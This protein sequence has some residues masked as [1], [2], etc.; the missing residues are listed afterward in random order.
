MGGSKDPATNSPSNVLL[1]CGSGT[2][3]CHGWVESH[4]AEAYDLGLLVHKWQRPDDVPAKL[5]HGTFMLDEEGGMQ[6]C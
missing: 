1:L 3:G 5:W 2:T 6:A 4:R